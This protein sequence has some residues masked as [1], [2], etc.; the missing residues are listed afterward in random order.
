M[1]KALQVVSGRTTNPSTTITGLTANTGDSFTVRSFDMAS[2]AYLCNAWAMAATAGVLRVRSPRLHDAAQ[3]IR[4]RTLA[5]NC[6]PLLGDESK[7]RLYPQDVLTFEISGGASETDMASLLLYYPDLP[8]IDSQLATWDEI[9]D[10]VANITTEEQQITTGGTAGDY[11]GSQAFNADFDTL[12]RN[13]K[14][15]VLGYVS[16]TRVCTVGITGPDTGNLRV[17]GPGEVAPD[18]TADWFIAQSKALGMPCIP[19]LNAANIGAT[20]FDVASTAT[21][22]SVNV[23]VILAE[24]AG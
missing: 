1:G 19:I 11:G 4:L 24:L 14:Y 8:G 5:S 22:A 2:P 17:G 12:K 10:R 6:R 21:S 7:Q 18:I 13:V 23:S 9:K 16:D 20:T 3:G 15:A